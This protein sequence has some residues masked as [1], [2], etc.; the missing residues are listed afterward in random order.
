[1]VEKIACAFVTQ[2][3]ACSKFGWF[4]TWNLYVAVIFES[5]E[6]INLKDTA[7]FFFS[8][9]LLLWTWTGWIGIIHFVSSIFIPTS[10]EDH[11]SKS[12]WVYYLYVTIKARL[13]AMVL[14][15]NWNLW[16]CWWWIRVNTF[17]SLY[18]DHD[19]AS[20]GMD[21]NTNY[22]NIVQNIQE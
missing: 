2:E 4:P 15:K 19:Y 9:F 3:Y 21:S 20:F 1:M 10:L 22:V 12:K 11:K 16:W 13:L 6:S 17:P 5:K 7:S 18:L 8:S 14:V